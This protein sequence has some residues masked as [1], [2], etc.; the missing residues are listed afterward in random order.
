MD[1]HAVGLVRPPSHAPTELVQLG[2]SEPLGLLH[3]HDGRIRD[4]DPD[5]DDRGGHQDVD[6]APGKRVHRSCSLVAFNTTMHD[7]DTVVGE[8]SLVEFRRHLGRRSQIQLRR[9]LHE[10]I[11]DE[12]L[13]PVC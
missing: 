8:D 12:H 9:L 5:L 13:T 11:H 1:Q 3:Q 6:L 2:Q 7:A 4:V 10:W